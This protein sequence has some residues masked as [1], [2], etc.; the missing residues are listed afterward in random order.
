KRLEQLLLNFSWM[1]AKLRRLG[2]QA[3]LSDYRLRRFERGPVPRLERVLGQSAHILTDQQQ[4]ASQLLARLQ[5]TPG[6]VEL[7]EAARADALRP[8]LRPLTTSLAGERST[9][10]LRPVE[11]ETLSSVTI[12]SNGLWAAH[13]SYSKDV[14]LWDLKQ[15]QAKGSIFRAEYHSYAMALS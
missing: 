3:L 13:V 2:I 4:L 14:M 10:W 15:W 7:L 9:R 5:S 12:S 11:A 6:I 8:W 1:S